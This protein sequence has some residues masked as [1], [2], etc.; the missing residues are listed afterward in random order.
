M[1][2]R[3][4]N[5]DPGN[6]EGVVVSNASRSRKPGGN[7]DEGT[8]GNRADAVEEVGEQGATV[9]GSAYLWA[10]RENG[11]CALHRVERRPRG[12]GDSVEVGTG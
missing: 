1:D 8:D 10:E 6:D 9:T 11:E 7:V 2:R 12:R 3:V 5:E 4:T